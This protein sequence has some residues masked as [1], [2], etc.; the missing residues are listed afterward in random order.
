[1]LMLLSQSRSTVWIDNKR[2][3]MSG[4]NLWIALNYQLIHLVD[5]LPVANWA[6]HQ[7]DTSFILFRDLYDLMEKAGKQD[8][9]I[10]YAPSDVSGQAQG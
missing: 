6:T 3:E 10:G 7:N 9:N 1:M 2:V 5:F 8:A 4:E